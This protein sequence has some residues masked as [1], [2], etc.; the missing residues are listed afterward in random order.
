LD[1]VQGNI[2]GTMT[3]AQIKNKKAFVWVFG[4]NQDG[5]LALGI[6]KD[7]LVPRFLAGI[8]G[9]SAKWIASSNHHTALITS[10]G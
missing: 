7:V 5:E 8:K 6:Y 10:E 9:S 2:E 4:K 1:V 3:E